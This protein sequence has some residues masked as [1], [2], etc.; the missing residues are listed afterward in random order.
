MRQMLVILTLFV[1][2]LRTQCLFGALPFQTSI[3]CPHSDSFP[4]SCAQPTIQKWYLYA[5]DS[6]DVEG[7]FFIVKLYEPRDFEYYTYFKVKRLRA[8]RLGVYYLNKDI[9]GR[10]REEFNL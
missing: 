10:E 7:G 3:S 9:V 4:K 2:V 1:C 6:L 5:L 8:D